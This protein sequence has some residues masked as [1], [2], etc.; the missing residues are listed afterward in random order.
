MT[1][2]VTIRRE[3]LEE[4]RDST[5]GLLMLWNAT[6]VSG[7][8]PMEIIKATAAIK[9]IESA[10]AAPAQDGWI[11]VSER[12]PENRAGMLYL[13]INTVGHDATIGSVTHWMPIP[14]APEVKP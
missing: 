6:R 1:D 3:L 9:V 5:E 12:L 7:C 2:T 11:P 4:L 10:L 13:A 8:L 14:P